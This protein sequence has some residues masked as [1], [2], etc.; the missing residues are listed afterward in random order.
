VELD[1]DAAVLVTSPSDLDLDTL[2]RLVP[3]CRDTVVL[4]W[5]L[6]DERGREE[7]RPEVVEVIEARLQELGAAITPKQIEPRSGALGDKEL[8]GRVSNLTRAES[9]LGIYILE[10]QRKKPRRRVV[11]ALRERATELSATTLHGD[12][13]IV[14]GGGHEFTCVPDLA[15]GVLASSDDQ[16]AIKTV[17]FFVPGCRD[18]VVLGWLIE[19]DQASTNDLAMLVKGRLAQLGPAQP[20]A[21]MH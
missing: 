5:V 21:T 7:P 3:G 11:D 16:A 14:D 13:N 4:E 6:D 9:L 18:A 20:G 12:M 19:G 17:E 1:L 10:A 2:D 8:R 15:A